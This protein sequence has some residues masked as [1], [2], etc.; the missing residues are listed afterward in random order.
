MNSVKNIIKKIIFP[1]DRKEMISVPQMV[2][3]SEMLNQKTAL[4]TGGS[5]GIGAAIAK[6][7]LKNGCKVVIAGR[8]ES[9]LQI[10]REELK[11]FGDI[12]YLIMDV[13]KVDII[14]ERIEKAIELF[15][16]HIDILVNSAGLITQ[17]S[18]FEITEAEYD[19]IMDVNIKGTYFVS[20][21]VS[22]NMIDNG[23][24][25]HIIN[26]SSASAVRPAWSPYQISKWGING[27]TKG[28]ADILIPYGIVV[29]A[30]APGPTMTP[31][32]NKNADGNLYHGHNPSGRYAT[33]DEIASLA[34]Y[35]ASDMGN[36]IVG[37]TI[38]VSGGGGTISYHN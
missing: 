30:I 24:K 37:D 12:K 33:P 3:T 22:K 21:I 7:F 26:I 23:I 10:T 5:S 16:D 11:K 25:G 31:M 17:G 34:V 35:L 1:K 6:A 29:N 4:I 36:L 28:L 15:E 19:K 38:Y 2:Y 9:S 18:F 20:Q 32:L 13:S 14:Q 8:N 27:L